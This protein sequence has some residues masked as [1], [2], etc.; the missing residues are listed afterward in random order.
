MVTWCTQHS[1]NHENHTRAVEQFFLLRIFL[2]HSR[3][4]KS[5]YR[6]FSLVLCWW[7]DRNVGG[8]SAFALFDGEEARICRMRGSQ[9]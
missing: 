3:E 5:L 6:S 2:E 7:L 8:V 4:R 1:L 9:A